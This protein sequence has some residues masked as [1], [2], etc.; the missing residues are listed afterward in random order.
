MKKEKLEFDNSNL[1]EL[2]EKE[3]I[4]ISGGDR[5]MFDL[6]YCL[7]KFSQMIDAAGGPSGFSRLR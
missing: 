7:G 3:L 6:G 5:F 2:D 1:I 4:N